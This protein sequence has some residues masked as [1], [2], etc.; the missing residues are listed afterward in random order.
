MI[1]KQTRAMLEATTV[2]PDKVRCFNDEPFAREA[3]RDLSEL[4]GD[5]RALELLMTH[6][7]MLVKAE[8]VVLRAVERIEE[9]I[10]EAG[11]TPVVAQPL[12][13]DRQAIRLLWLYV[14]N[15]ATLERL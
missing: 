12:R 8:S 9:R 4:A 6:G 7:T 5:A 3:M 15:G 14:L 11:F 1:E 2:L 13:L 10:R